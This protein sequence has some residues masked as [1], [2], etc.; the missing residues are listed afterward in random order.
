MAGKSCRGIDEGN[1]ENYQTGT[2]IRRIVPKLMMEFSILFSLQRLFKGKFFI[3]YLVS[4]GYINIVLF[5]EF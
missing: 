3:Y 2:I 5:S 1:R 4:G